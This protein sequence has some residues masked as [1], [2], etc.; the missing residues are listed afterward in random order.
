MP[1]SGCFGNGRSSERDCSSSSTS[2]SSSQLSR[3]CQLPAKFR[4]C[5]DMILIPPAAFTHTALL[6]CRLSHLSYLTNTIF[7]PHLCP[8]VV[9]LLTFSRLLVF[10]TTELFG[11]LN[12]LQNYFKPKPVAGVLFISRRLVSTTPLTAPPRPSFFSP[13]GQPSATIGTTSRSIAHTSPAA[14]LQRQKKDP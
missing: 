4:A 14:Q 2:S 6:R 13:V 1:V 5:V 9:N 7:L 11:A 3:S 8:Y 12:I 10:P